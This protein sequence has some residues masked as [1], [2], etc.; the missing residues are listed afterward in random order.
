MLSASEA[1]GWATPP[2]WLPRMLRCAQ[3]DTSMV[4]SHGMP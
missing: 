3:H 4:R 1:F 2:G